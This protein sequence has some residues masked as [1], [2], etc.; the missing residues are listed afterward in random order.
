MSLTKRNFTRAIYV[1]D[2]VVHRVPNDNWDNQSPCDEWTAR[3]VLRHQC[4]VL[5][6]MAATLQSGET[7]P[8]Q[9]IDSAENPVAV[10]TET[11][12]RI[13]AELDEPA[14]LDREGKFWFGPMSVDQWVQVVQWDPLTHAWDI[15]EAAGIE[16]HIPDD[17]ALISHEV[18]SG[19]R[20]TLHKW[21]LIADEVEISEDASASEKFLALIGRDP[22]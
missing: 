14:I 10:W 13:L 7:V 4:G 21:G 15:S 16:S 5:Q 17:L 2:A 11:R 12:D 6:A 8:P 9:P 19:M 18:I 20:E 3:D 1:F 22:R